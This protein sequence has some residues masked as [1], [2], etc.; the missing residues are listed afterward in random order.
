M[1]IN[2]KALPI[3]REAGHNK[4][5]ISKYSYSQMILKNIPRSPSVPSGSFS[6]QL[7]QPWSSQ[8]PRKRKIASTW[9]GKRP[10]KPVKHSEKVCW[11]IRRRRFLNLT[12]KIARPVDWRDRS[13]ARRGV[14]RWMCRRVR[15]R[16]WMANDLGINH[17]LSSLEDRMTSNW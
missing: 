5:P 14:F 10:S 3:N 12:I 13:R 2:R 17:C 8:P 1:H 9:R 11:M 7:P 6:T 15:N 4:I 16:W